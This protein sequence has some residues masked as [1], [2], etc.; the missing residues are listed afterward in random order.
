[1]EA[2]RKDSVVMMVLVLAV[3][4]ALERIKLLELHPPPRATAL[5][6]PIRLSFWPDISTPA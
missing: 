1:M 2:D 5:E 3:L 6:Q 4:A